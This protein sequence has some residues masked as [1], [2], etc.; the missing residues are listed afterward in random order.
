MKIQSRKH[1]EKIEEVTVEQWNRMQLN[2]I[3]HN[4]KIID[5]SDIAQA[6]KD[7]IDIKVAEFT[8][9]ADPVEQERED[10]MNQLDELGISYRKNTGLEK[11]RDKLETALKED[12]NTEENE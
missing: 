7:N 1:K 5:N 11:L 12:E 2:G 3:A 10:I 6:A 8:K 4:W 9:V